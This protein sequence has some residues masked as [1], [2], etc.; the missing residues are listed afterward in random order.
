MQ[1]GVVVTVRSRRETRYRPRCAS[2]IAPIRPPERDAYMGQPLASRRAGCG[3]GH[4][5]TAP[6]HRRRRPRFVR[7]STPG[8]V[9]AKLQR[10]ADGVQL[11]ALPHTYGRPG[12]RTGLQLPR[13]RRCQARPGSWL[14]PCDVL[15]AS[16]CPG[17]EFDHLHPGIR[18]PPGPSISSVDLPNVGKT[19]FVVS[20]TISRS[21]AS[22]TSR[23]APIP[24]DRLRCSGWK[25]LVT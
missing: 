12:L 20:S 8:P 11:T 5:R 10:R 17:C 2:A 21:S 1:A 22:T 13:P 3:S 9:I 24:V 23:S 19:L 15:P 14:K 18:I 6:G 7:N 4:Q 16:R 25:S